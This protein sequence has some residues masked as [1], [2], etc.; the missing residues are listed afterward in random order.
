M[1]RYLLILGYT[2]IDHNGGNPIDK[3]EISIFESETNSE[4]KRESHRLINERLRG[5]F[6]DNRQPESK[7]YRIAEEIPIN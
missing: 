1:D 2:A 3:Q 4:A 7:L 6:T 5:V